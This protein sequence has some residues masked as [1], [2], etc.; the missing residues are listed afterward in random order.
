MN[1][2]MESLREITP[3]YMISFV[4]YFLYRNSITFLSNEQDGKTDRDFVS[5]ISFTDAISSL[6][7]LF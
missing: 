2:T 1:V 3:A 5:C 4:N 6:E 7:K